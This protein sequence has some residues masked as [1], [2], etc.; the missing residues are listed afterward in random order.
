[1]HLVSYLIP[2]YNKEEY[3]V[4]A[5]ESVLKEASEELD[6]EICLV[7]DGSSDSSLTVVSS[8]FGEHPKVKIHAFSKNK[9][10]N[11]AFN[12]AF[13]MAA[14]DFVCLLGADD[15]LVPGRTKRLLDETLATE[16][17]VYGGLFRY[18]NDAKATIEKVLPAPPSY[19]KNLLG[20]SLSGGCAMLWKKDAQSVFPLPENI[21]FEDWWISF[22][23]LKNNRVAVLTEPVLYYRLHAGNDC[24]TVV[25]TQDSVA[26][27]YARHYDFFSAIK[28][29]IKGFW[30]NLYFRKSVAL[31][32]AF[33]GRGKLKYF[34]YFP[35]DVTWMKTVS[36]M[37]FGTSFVYQAKSRID[38]LRNSARLR[39]KSSL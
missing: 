25:P 37:I 31:R 21:K 19:L 34:L 15:F 13:E 14:G 2:L 38:Q 22:F 4:E 23:L 33:F 9:G 32:D 24:G 18:D 30:P 11:A 28:P 5:I 26:K 3:I 8:L 7:D 20:S 39:L 6:V 16:K 27:D 10:K 17:S 12:S 29:Y 36:F 1:M 35:I